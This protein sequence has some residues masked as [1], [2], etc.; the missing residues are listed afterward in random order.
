MNLF[1]KL[2]F[3]LLSVILLSTVTSCT[4]NL[5]FST[6]AADKLSFSTDTVRFDTVF[7]SIGSSTRQFKIY[8]HSTKPLNISSIELKGAAT[9][10]FSVVVDG[11]RGPNFTNIEIGAKD[12][13]FVFVEVKV[14]PQNQNSPI[15]IQD[16]LVFLTNGNQ[17]HVRFEAYGQDVIIFRTKKRKIIEII[18][19]GGK[20]IKD[21]LYLRN[22]IT[23]GVDTTFTNNRP[24]LIYDSLIVAKGAKL[25][26][27]PGVKLYFHNKA[28]CRIDGQI[29]SKGTAA[30][31]VLFRADRMDY[32]LPDLPFDLY[33]GQWRGVSI[34]KD[35]YDNEMEY[36]QIRN[37]QYALQLDT[38]TTTQT[39]IRLTNCKFNN[40]T[41][42]VLSAFNCKMEANGCE[43]SNGGSDVVKLLG[44]FYTFTHC[45]LMS[46]FPFSSYN[47]PS[48]LHL[49]NFIY[50]SGVKP[51]VIWI[52]QPLTQATFN[53]CIIYGNRSSEIFFDNQPNGYAIQNDP[54][55][56]HFDHC[57]F[58]DSGT[59][60][61]DFVESV[62]NKD[63]KF[64]NVN[65]NDK[66]IYDLRLDSLSVAIDMANPAFVSNSL[67]DMNG[68]SRLA[69]GKPDIGAYERVKV[70]GK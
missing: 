29:S 52:N 6:S 36:T 64:L 33:T 34:S 53:N 24:I 31:P 59:D 44:G 14:N 68:V 37:G 1:F 47:S 55:N 3:S 49:I 46:A 35:S 32:M 63:P 21:T 43:F 65:N 61:A 26:I 54:F 11:Q 15:F 22:T 57:L 10:G 16:S 13:I 12:S 30:Q 60:D 7:T 39:K 38:A 8:N 69:D 18:D 51:N 19:K 20:N 48:A 70:K 2:F 25:T 62:W 27:E 42:V 67:T 45:T 66:F 9:S 23:E 5:N 40:V 58:K 17:Q 4:E 50:L 28:F 41:G 56:Y